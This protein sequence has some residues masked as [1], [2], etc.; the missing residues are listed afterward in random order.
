MDSFG[1]LITNIDAHL[2]SAATEG[3]EPVMVR[4]AGRTV[5]GVVDTYA[6]RPEKSL[7]A[8][9]GSSGRLE[10]AVV[11][12]NA[13]RRLGVHVGDAVVVEW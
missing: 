12:G 5:E 8:L 3:A 7:V 10:I 4:C 9:V 6:E 2:L 11:G 1:N 13:A